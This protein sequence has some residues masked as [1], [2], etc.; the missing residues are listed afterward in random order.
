MI[1]APLA[2][3]R[4]DSFGLQG[5]HLIRTQTRCEGDPEDP[6]DEDYLRRTQRQSQVKS[7]SSLR[8]FIK[9]SPCQVGIF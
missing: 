7:F 6:H 9:L 3:F 2:L 5:S 1:L 4:P 8:T